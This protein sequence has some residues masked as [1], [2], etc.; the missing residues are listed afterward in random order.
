VLNLIVSYAL[1]AVFNA[2]SNTRTDA[3]AAQDYA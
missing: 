3:T 2:I 1:S